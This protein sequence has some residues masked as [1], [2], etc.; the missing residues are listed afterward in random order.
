MT[1]IRAEIIL[2]NR[3]DA[4][5]HTVTGY[6]PRC[7]QCAVSFWRQVLIL[8]RLCMPTGAI[9]SV[10]IR[11]SAKGPSSRSK[12]AIMGRRFFVH[13]SLIL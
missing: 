9:P 7:W 6:S 5:G 4:A 12:T 13:T 8:L 10:E 11:R 3:C 1:P 2:S